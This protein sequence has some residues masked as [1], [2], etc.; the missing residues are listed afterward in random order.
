VKC[1]KKTK[2]YQYTRYR[3]SP[4]R[5]KGYS[6]ESFYNIF[7][8]LHTMYKTKVNMDKEIL[9]AVVYKIKNHI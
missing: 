8:Y 7:V 6:S 2:R 1:P 5:L 9:K 3:F 4:D